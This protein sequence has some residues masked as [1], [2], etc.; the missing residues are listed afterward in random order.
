[1]EMEVRSPGLVDQQRDAVLVRDRR[2]PLDVGGDA[3]VRR[4]DDVDGLD[5][6]MLDRAS[7]APSPA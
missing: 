7:R 1:M 4:A 2:D 5:V 3:V 6:G